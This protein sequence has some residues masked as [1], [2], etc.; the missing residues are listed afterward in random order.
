MSTLTTHKRTVHGV[1]AAEDGT[2]II[3]EHMIG[4]GQDRSKNFKNITSNVSS[5]LY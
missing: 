5:F 4:I 3:L 2:E 1:I